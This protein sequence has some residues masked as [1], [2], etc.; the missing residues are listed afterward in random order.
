MLS[1]DIVLC[2]YALLKLSVVQKTLILLELF[3]EEKKQFQN[4]ATNI[5]FLRLIQ[6][7]LFDTRNCL[8]Q[9]HVI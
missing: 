9:I 1:C 6:T 2:S 7:S 8:R 3:V 5:G 4:F